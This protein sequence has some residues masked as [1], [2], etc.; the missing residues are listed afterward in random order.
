M[1]GLIPQSN[2][3]GTSTFER[4][5]VAFAYERGWR[6]SF[7]RAAFPGPDE[8]FKLAEAALLPFA[9]GKVLVDASCGSGLF[10]RRFAKSGNYGAVVAL[11]F[12]AAMLQQARAFA[13]EEGLLDDEE[14]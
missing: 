3:V 6:Q 9:E 12:S 8:E 2:D 5:Q 4:P 10:T 7:A 1:R 14:T 11:D 13:K